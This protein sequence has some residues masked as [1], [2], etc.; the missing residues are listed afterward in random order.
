MALEPEESV[1]ARRVSKAFEP[2]AVFLTVAL[3]GGWHFRLRGLAFALYALYI[4]S[5]GV[6]MGAARVRIMRVMHT[7]WDISSRPKRVRV[8]L[9]LLGFSSVLYAII[10]LWRSPSLTELYAMFLVWL[11]GFF[12]LTLKIKI[13]GHLSVFVLT[14]GLLVSWYEMSLWVFA[15]LI[16]LLSW[17]RVK[18]RRHTIP[19]VVLGT[20]YSFGILF[21]YNRL[22]R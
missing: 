3:I 19:E 6:L 10:T 5:V 15:V 9:M 12:L 17:S 22:P 11:I 7:N 20:L 4:I 8:L 14:L 16:P 21:A 18:L 13:S 2:M 1:L